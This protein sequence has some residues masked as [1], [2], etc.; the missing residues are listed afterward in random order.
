MLQRAQLAPVRALHR[1]TRGCKYDVFDWGKL[2]PEE[3]PPLRKNLPE[4]MPKFPFGYNN[5]NPESTVGGKPYATPAD[6]KDWAA[7]YRKWAATAG[8]QHNQHND[9]IHLEPFHNEEEHAK[10]LQYIETLTDE[11]KRQ[12][13]VTIDKERTKPYHVLFPH[14]RMYAV[15]EPAVHL[16]KGQ[17]YTTSQFGSNTHFAV[18]MDG[19]AAPTWKVIKQCFNPKEPPRNYLKEYREFMA[20]KKEGKTEAIEASSA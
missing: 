12:Q 17:E 10:Y 20:K 2:S 7:R 9:L 1:Q 18:L 8:P 3:L 13:G 14:Q 19:K 15:N 5:P 4:D 11:E 16:R 6:Y